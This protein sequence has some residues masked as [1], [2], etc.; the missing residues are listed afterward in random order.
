MTRTIPGW[1][2]LFLVTAIG[3]SSLSAQA[4]PLDSARARALLEEATTALR[5]APASRSDAYLVDRL[6]RLRDT[7]GLDG[8]VVRDLRI[9]PTRSEPTGSELERLVAEAVWDDAIELV[10]QSD[11]MDFPPNG[12]DELLR[13]LIAA[14][15]DA[16]AVEAAA[17]LNRASAA[18]YWILNA[19]GS[20]PETRMARVA[21]LFEKGV[22]PAESE[23]DVKRQVLWLI[24][25]SDPGRAWAAT[26]T[27]SSPPDRA[28]LRISLASR[29]FWHGDPQADQRLR[30]AYDDVLGLNDEVAREAHL[31]DVRQVCEDFESAACQEFS[32]PPKPAEVAASQ[33]GIDASNAIAAGQLD[34]AG[35]VLD[36]LAAYV[37]PS[38]IALRVV[39]ALT[40]TPLAGPAL[41]PWIIRW[42]AEAET[43]ANAAEPAVADSLL[44]F[45]AQLLAP[46]NPARAF[47]LAERIGDAALRTRTYAA[48]AYSLVDVDVMSAWHAARRGADEY[49]AQDVAARL[50]PVLRSLGDTVAAAEALDMMRPMRAS[51]AQLEW[52]A[53]LGRSGQWS[54]ARAFA[55]DALKRWSAFDEPSGSP[56]RLR[57]D[58]FVQL[59]LY[60]ELVAWARAL[61]QPGRRA[62]ALT[63]LVEA[64]PPPYE[65]SGP[66][67]FDVI[68]TSCLSLPGCDLIG[69]TCSCTVQ[70]S[71]HPS[72]GG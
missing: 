25:E 12:F 45:A 2:I 58:V 16:R 5:D 56:A 8:S 54:T 7:W 65:A 13:G 71:D 28:A 63:A 3:E 19:E 6:A 59:D 14:G 32:L 17:H 50:Y 57:L 26:D 46:R 60:D 39:E 51:N 66:E 49:H 64:A 36:S 37:A 9:E 41:E 1:S 42:S 30:A 31:K 61:E 33:L 69:K 20:P 43:L 15:F 34:E 22:I 44:G 4:T 18:T 38:Q 52:A 27:V 62:E 23:L 24:S 67:R 29:A 48:M 68:D 53:R 72:G 70:I 55:F 47:E 21:E 10:R 35:R 40:R 11:P